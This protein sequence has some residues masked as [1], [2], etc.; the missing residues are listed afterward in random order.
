MKKKNKWIITLLAAFVLFYA[1]DRSIPA[2]LLLIAAGTVTAT[3]AV[4]ELLERRRK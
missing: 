1:T 2:A 3:E 4:C